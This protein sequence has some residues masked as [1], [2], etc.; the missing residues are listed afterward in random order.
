VQ[1][2]SRG[3]NAVSGLVLRN[4]N[5]KMQTLLL[6]NGHHPASVDRTAADLLEL[7]GNSLSP[8]A[9]KAKYG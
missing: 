6:S 5:R 3:H 8:L 1:A 9:E 7:D 4:V 2:L